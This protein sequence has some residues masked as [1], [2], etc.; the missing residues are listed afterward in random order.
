MENAEAK[1]SKHI[2]YDV[3]FAA[4]NRNIYSSQK[5]FIL[6]ALTH[7]RDKPTYS[8]LFEIKVQC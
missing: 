8:C 6:H 2:I 7:L 4:A 1:I 5:Y 3:I